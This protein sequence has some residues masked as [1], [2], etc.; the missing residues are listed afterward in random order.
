[1]FV[2]QPYIYRNF[3]E[4]VNQEGY[5]MSSRDSFTAAQEAFVN[6]NNTNGIPFID[7]QKFLEKN[8]QD[9]H[10]IFSGIQYYFD[11]VH[12]SPAGN[13]KMAE[14]LFAKLLQHK[15]LN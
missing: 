14:L 12:L 13:K 7:W 2:L 10:S 6:F 3:P 1:M 11:H 4:L 8:R 9:N 5:W 15:T